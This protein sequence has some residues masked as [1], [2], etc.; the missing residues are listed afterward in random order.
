MFG[1]VSSPLYILRFNSAEQIADKGLMEGVTVYYAPSVREYT[2]YILVQE[3]KLYVE[4]LLG[5]FSDGFSHV[6][7]KTSSICVQHLLSG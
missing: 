4:A 6:S 5:C 1:P 2:G 7:G 3:L